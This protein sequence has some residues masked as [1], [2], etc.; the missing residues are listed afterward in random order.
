MN[1][2][3]GFSVNA[4]LPKA[5]SGGALKM[6]LAALS[7]AQWLQPDP[8]LALRKA[9]F[10]AHP[11]AVCLSPEGLAP[12]A[13]LAAML[14]TSGGLEAAAR[15]AWEDMCLLEMA[16]G[17]DIY[18]L[19]GAAVAFPTDWNPA[20]KLGLPLS[21]LHAP[22]H[23][24]RE[25]LASGVDHFMASLKPGR[26]FGR[27]NW[28]V[29]PTCALRWRS[30]RK[31]ADGFAGVT[32]ANAGERLFVR[33]ERQTL[34]RLPQTGAIVFTIGIYVSPLA[35]LTPDNGLRLAQALATIPQAEA[36]RRRTKS[37]APAL[38]NWVKQ[39]N[40]AHE[41]PA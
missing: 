28:F 41:K 8:D 2:R 27:C 20:D 37:F 7:E 1:E 39:Q 31:G 14:G 22:I 34:R 16:K 26:I 3:L 25:Q 36:E 13:E 11:D 6:G 19:T 5:R 29:A 4:L 21:A 17:E 32:D 18:R 12:G 23:G 38:A 33:C 35:L 15:A 10:D 40:Q 30:A 9:A 24:Y